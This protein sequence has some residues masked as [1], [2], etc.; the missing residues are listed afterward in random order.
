MPLNATASQRKPRLLFAVA[1][2]PNRIGGIE[3]FAAELAR[4]LKEKGWD[5]TMCFEDSP[6]P[7]VEAFLLAPGNVQLI[8]M[9]DQEGMSFA[10]ARSFFHLLR[11]HK[12]NVLL[13][14]LGGAVRWWPLL[15]RVMGVQR[16]VYWDGTSRTAATIHYRASARVK[17]LMQSLS[18]S[19][20]ATKF[21]KA[22]S[23]REGIVPPER[24]VVIYNS[25][26][27]ERDLGDAAAFRANYGIPE[28]RL[29]VTQVSWLV[30]E[31]GID[32]ALRAVVGD[33]LVAGLEQA[34]GHARP[35]VAQPDEPDPHAS[36]LPRFPVG[37]YGC[38]QPAG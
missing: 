13:Y 18:R 14:S 27:N 33:H 36:T 35:H 32:L 28:G 23:D 31:K 3:A 9:R 25:V 4:Q 34:S 22:C 21:V 29:I 37:G 11:E 16:T 26:D 5:L 20:C 10:S 1:S 17:L 6:P 7:L 8:V 15:A 38:L 12:P 30:P 24:S 19:V 2:S